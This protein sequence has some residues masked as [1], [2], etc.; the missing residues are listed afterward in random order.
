MTHHPLHPIAALLVSLGGAA[1]SL[2]RYLTARAAISLL[3][4]V[5]VSAFPWGTLAAN[6]L[7][8]GCMGLLT[9]WLAR[10]SETGGLSNEDWRL[11][12][13][14]GVLGGYTT[15]S[16][17]A[18]EFVLFAERGAW[19]AAVLYVGVSLGA[20]FGALLAGLSFMRAIG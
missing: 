9:G 6:V 4:P 15:F 20:G 3:G 12:L 11:L 19:G 17:F 8:S 13:A 14:V 7:G 18:L 5:A 10:H 16:S 2:A 1:G